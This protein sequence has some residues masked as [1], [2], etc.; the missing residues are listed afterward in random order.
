VLLCAPGIANTANR[1]LALKDSGV[2]AK[3]VKSTSL[4]PLRRCLDQTC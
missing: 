3:V 1:F 2:C 4:A